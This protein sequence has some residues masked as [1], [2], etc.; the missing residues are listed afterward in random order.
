MLPTTRAEHALCMFHTYIH[1]TLHMWG[2]LIQTRLRVENGKT[3]RLLS[4]II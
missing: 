3:N 4:L 1:V 2:N